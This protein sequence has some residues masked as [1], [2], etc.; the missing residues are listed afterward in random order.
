MFCTTTIVPRDRAKE[1]LMKAKTE[2]GNDLKQNGMERKSSR[3]EREQ[4]A[5]LP[6]LA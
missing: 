1:D 2:K 5:R 3:H 6:A 4:Q